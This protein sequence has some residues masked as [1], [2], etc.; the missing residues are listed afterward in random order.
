MSVYNRKGGSG[1]RGSLR[2]Q[3]NYYRN[4]LKKRLIEEQAFKEARGVGSIE[5]EVYSMFKHFNY[6]K[7][8]EQGITRKVGSRT[9]RYIGEQAVKIQIESLRRRAS[10]SAQAN[11]FIENYLGAM[12]EMGFDEDDMSEVGRLLKS[13]SIDKLR[14][15]IEKGL[16]PSIEY[17][18]ADILDYEEFVK[19][20]ENAVKHGISKEEVAEVQ[21][22][23]KEL[24]KVVKA[25]SDILGK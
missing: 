6:D 21:A 7:V 25:R 12:G 18:Y 11:D 9:V 8:F 19:A 3:F 2:V 15:L 16:L 4:Q 17:I 13:C 20:V 14:L 5:S 22:R 23:K 1:R 10:R 24:V